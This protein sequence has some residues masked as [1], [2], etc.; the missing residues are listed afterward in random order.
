M[1]LFDKKYCDI[2]GEKIGLLGNKKLKDGNM[3]KKCQSK[4]SPFFRERRESTV[5]EIK[6]QLEYR[7]ANKNALSAFHV[8]STFGDDFKIYI[9]EADKK[10][11]VTR[12]AINKFSEVN[13]DIIDFSQV[14]SFDV[15]IDE[16]EKEVKY[17]DAEGNYKSFL[18]Q[19]FA[20]SYDFEVKIMVNHPYF[21]EITFNLNSSSV[22]NEAETS[23]DLDGI[24]P[25]QY[26]V[27]G[28]GL[29]Q[30]SNKE[31]VKN[32][33]EYRKYI[34]QTEELRNLF[35]NARNEGNN[36][37]AQKGSSEEDAITCP[38]CGAK[39]VKDPSGTCKV[40]GAPLA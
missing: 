6:E 27:A 18:P 20:Y 21:N 16:D 36:I 23:V 4:L 17:N 10:F 33:E 31:E 22:D 37:P 28:F 13:P 2:C 8:T 35:K 14:V 38:Y 25:E 15:S 30:T 26:K 5:S 34:K 19:R 3:C 1:G 32:S 9:D 11:V 7:E 24:A 12:A 29:N 39:T 40:C